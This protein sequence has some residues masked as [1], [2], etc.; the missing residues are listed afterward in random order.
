MSVG[1]LG[2]VAYYAGCIRDET[3]PTNRNKRLAAA[4][5]AA[6]SPHSRARVRRREGGFA[7]IPSASLEH[8]RCPILVAP[9]ARRGDGAGCAIQMRRGRC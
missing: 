1:W 8:L 7:P 4:G 5:A 9:P 2:F 3:Q 6:R